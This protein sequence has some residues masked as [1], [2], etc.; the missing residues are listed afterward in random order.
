MKSD[1]L[2]HYD[3]GK[4][5]KSSCDAS[6]YGVGACLS[7]VMQ[8]G[9][10]R[11]VAFASRTL[12]PA[13]KNYAHLEK[14]A[15]A[16]IYGVRH[17]HKYLMGRKFT[18]VADHRPLLRILGAKEGVPTLAAARLQRWA[19]ILSAY[20]YEL[21]YRGGQ[22]NKKADVLSRLSIPVEVIDPNEQIFGV[23][24]CEP[25]P[26]TA[27]G[28]AKATQLNVVPR[29]AYQY[30]RYGWT[31]RDVDQSLQPFAKRA[32]ELSIGGGYLLWG[33][34]VIIPEELRKTVLAQ[35]HEGHLGTSKMKALARS[36]VWWPNLD[37]DIEDLTRSCEQCQNQKSRPSTTKPSHPW[38]YPTSPWE[39]VHADFAEFAGKQY[40]L[41]VDAFSKWPVVHELGIHATTGQTI[42]AMRRSFS[43]HGFPQRLVTNNVPQF[44]AQDFKEFMEANGIKHQLTPPYHPASNGQVERMVQELKKSLKGRPAGRS[45]SHQVS[46]FLL[47]YRTTPHIATGKTPAELLIKRIPRTKLSLLRPEVSDIDRDEQR[48]KFEEATKRSRQL[49][50][51]CKVS[52]WNPR[53]DSRGRWLVGTVDQQL[54][55]TNYLVN[56]EGHS[57]HVHID[58]MR[59]RDQWSVPETADV[60]V[61]EIEVEEI[62]VP[63][64]PV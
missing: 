8:D 17:L 31:T 16:L 44:R 27:K 42:A 51:G 63:V 37:R 43:C 28:I 1:L 49:D 41:I 32:N 64:I 39:R 3:L 38:I 62:P 14:E 48:I 33:S 53:Q 11:P 45:I 9:T 52:V 59:W 2:V 18:L 26:M 30:T 10:E 50:P 7:H 6:P 13:E 47:Y 40:L 29:R 5:I 57:R 60:S 15:L 55:A 46:S 24:Y 35:I 34:R 36:Y 25:L 58:Q 61:P 20:S 56:V 12:A 54:G 21:E 22:E 4:P 19:L 23:D